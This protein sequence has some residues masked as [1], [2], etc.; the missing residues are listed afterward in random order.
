MRADRNNWDA[1]STIVPPGRG[2]WLHGLFSRVELALGGPWVSYSGN[3]LVGVNGLLVLPFA[4]FPVTML[5]GS[6]PS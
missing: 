6:G 2:H 4:R 1:D 3:D 5:P